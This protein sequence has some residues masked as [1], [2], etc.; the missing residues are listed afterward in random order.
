VQYNARQK[1]TR[2]AQREHQIDDG[3]SP[4]ED[5]PGNY[6]GE[7]FGTKCNGVKQTAHHSGKAED[8][9]E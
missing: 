6:I 8:A 2:S 3:Y 9:E 5:D 4:G 7:R 1:P